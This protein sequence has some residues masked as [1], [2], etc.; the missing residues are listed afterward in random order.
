MTILKSD[1]WSDFT[2][3]VAAAVAEGADVKIVTGP[4]AN[5]GFAIEV[6]DDDLPDEDD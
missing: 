2:R 5:G 1:N 6:S 3:G 4:E